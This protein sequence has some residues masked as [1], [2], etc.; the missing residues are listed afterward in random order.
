MAGNFAIA[1][2]LVLKMA[3]CAV[4]A[5]AGGYLII[6]GFAA[7]KISG[8]EALV[9]AVGLCVLLFVCVALTLRGGAGI[10]ILFAAVGGSALLF[11]VLARLADRRVARGLFDEEMDRYMQ[12][13]ELDPENVAAHSLLADAYRRMG[14]L[15]KAVEEYEEAVRLDPSLREERYWLERLRAKLAGEESRD[16]L[17][18]RCRTPRPDKAAE[19]PDCGRMYSAWEVWRHKLQTMD[20]THQAILTAVG[21]GA[22]AVAL[23]ATALAPGLLKLLGVIVVLL[24]P[25]AA[26]ILMGRAG[27]RAG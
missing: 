27:G 21:V 22:V 26:F 15:E 18:P 3:I 6:S 16:L 4:I 13:L 23:A 9:L 25:V 7:R 8:R 14:K 19:C 10:L 1:L 2:M 12:A 20:P 17:C 11:A 5:F 24:A